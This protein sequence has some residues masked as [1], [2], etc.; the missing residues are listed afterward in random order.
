MA[1]E[2]SLTAS[3]KALAIDLLRK[4]LHPA[5][6]TVTKEAPKTPGAPQVRVRLPHS[7][8]TT[9]HLQRYTPGSPTSRRSHTVWVLRSAPPALVERLRRN[10]ESFVDVTRGIVR[11]ELP[12]ILIDRSDLRPTR[13]RGATRPLRRAFS[14]RASL[15]SRVLV[16]E[17]KK[18]W[19][20]RGLAAAASVS[21]MTASHVVRQLEAI[22]AIRSEVSG[23]SKR[24]Q[25]ASLEK[26]ILHWAAEYEWTVNS[27]L[28][29]FAPIGDPTRFLDQLPSAIDGRKWALTLHAGASLVA[30][31]ASW[32]KIHVYVDV[33]KGEILHDIAA[34][35]GYATGDQG[36]LVLMQ[37]WYR[38]SVWYDLQRVRDMPIVS[39]VQLVLDLWH[40]PVRG[41]EQAEHLLRT[42]LQ[43]RSNNV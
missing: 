7:G 12:S 30:P 35:A 20:L 14:D 19:H 16:S 17:P 23:R 28:P 6:S 33:R 18:M 32:D 1:N 27:R 9:L 13:R 2:P 25:L 40:Y 4:S 24:I 43:Q 22:G 5:G 41:R 10:H 37:P 3:D 34:T 15:I 36:R 29:V 42:V 11:L 8:E 26:L 39:T 21:T 31:M 38:Q